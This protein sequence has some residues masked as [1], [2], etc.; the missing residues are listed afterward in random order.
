MKYC[1]VSTPFLGE[2]VYALP[3]IGMPCSEKALAE[4]MCRVLDHLLEESVVAKIADDLYC[5]G[6][7]P[8]ALLQNWRK[9]LQAL[10]KC[11]LRLVTSKTVI[12][13]QSTAILG[14]VWNSITLR[15]TPHRISAFSSCPVKYLLVSSLVVLLSSLYL[16]TPS[17]AVILKNGFCGL[18][19]S[20]P[21]SVMPRQLSL[22]LTP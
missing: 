14:W 6:H 19:T 2:G 4:F 17:L 5:C 22:P 12:N 11:N 8:Q 10:H 9:V 13:P 16:T 20:I 3:A 15:A 1:G 7:T 18:T 21:P